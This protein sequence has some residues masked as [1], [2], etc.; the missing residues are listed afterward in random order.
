MMRFIA[1]LI[2]GLENTIH[3][4]SEKLNRDKQK[5]DL[6]VFLTVVL[7]KLSIVKNVLFTFG[8]VILR[9]A[10]SLDA[11]REIERLQPVY[12]DVGGVHFHA[13]GKIRIYQS[14]LHPP[15]LSCGHCQYPIRCWYVF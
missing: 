12:L 11:V 7:H 10:L 14:S 1:S 3:L 9:F 15:P 5:Y 13:S 6:L 8:F 2:D 4:Y